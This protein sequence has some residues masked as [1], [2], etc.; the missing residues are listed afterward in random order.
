MKKHASGLS[1]ALLPALGLLAADYTADEVA[2]RLDSLQTVPLT[3]PDEISKTLPPEGDNVRTCPKCGRQMRLKTSAQLMRLLYERIAPKLYWQGLDDSSLC[4]HCGDGKYYVLTTEHTLQEVK[5]EDGTV[6]PEVVARPSGRVPVTV[7]DLLLLYRLF[8]NQPAERRTD[9]LFFFRRYWP[10]DSSFSVM[11]EDAY[12]ALVWRI[13]RLIRSNTSSKERDKK[14]SL[15]R[16]KEERQRLE[17][18]AA[19]FQ[20]LTEN[21]NILRKNDLDKM[22]K[23]M[24]DLSR[25]AHGFKDGNAMMLTRM[26][27]TG[28]LARSWTPL[29]CPKCHARF[30]VMNG[31]NSPH[32]TPLG[33]LLALLRLLDLTP[34]YA[35]LCPHCHPDG[36]APRRLKVVCRLGDQTHASELSP[37]DLALLLQV[38]ARW[39]GQETIPTGAGISISLTAGQLLRLRA[40]LQGAD[41]TSQISADKMP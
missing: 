19:I 29:T 39:P 17:Q 36:E 8:F 12:Q 23:E 25:R 41:D 24:A 32:M 38:L 33:D 28:D 34:D 30:Y 9:L 13:E 3:V 15:A 22:L 6:R 7:E 5:Q 31:T 11:T 2:K 35:S 1:L 10:S 40:I 26:M 18:D 37:T 16:A 21:A 4:P 14:A 20:R 27:I